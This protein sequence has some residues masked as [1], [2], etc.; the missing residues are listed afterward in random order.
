MKFKDFNVSNELLDA[1]NVMKFEDASPVQEQAIPELLLG[2]DLIGQAQ[3]G[4]GKTA[5]FGIPIIERL[6]T[7]L[8]APQALILCPTRELA[9]QIADELKRLAKFKTG[10]SIVAL[11]GGQ[12]IEVQFRA[13]RKGANILVA[14]PGRMIDHLQRGSVKLNA[15]TTIVLDEVDEMLN[16]GFK[17]NIEDIF[18]RITNKNRQTVFFS[19][20]ISE[21]IMALAVKYQHEPKLVKVGIGSS[22]PN[23]EQFYCEVLKERAKPG[24]LA[25]LITQYNLK[26]SLV[27]CNTKRQVDYLVEDLKSKGFFAN[28]L[29]GDMR[30]SQRDRVMDSFRR[31]ETQILVATD[32]A[33]RGINVKEIQ[34]VFNYDLPDA[35]EYYVHRIGR[36]GRAGKLGKAF[37]FVVGS[38][39]HKLNSIKRQV[40]V[41]IASH[42]IPTPQAQAV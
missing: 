13:L 18:S 40:K 23:V 17:Q 15:L 34:G 5:A 39:I 35:P 21:R 11:Y 26:P 32:V 30:Q 29:H 16:V 22:S 6:D 28:G 41:Q 38:Q 8:R 19:A 10:T 37:S 12:N 4:T 25:D 7:T 9:C 14:T 24:I 20:T 42:K 1:L 27:F 3:T 36:T 33:A 2:H 31:G